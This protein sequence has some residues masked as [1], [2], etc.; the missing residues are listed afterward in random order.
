MCQWIIYGHRNCVPFTGSTKVSMRC[1]RDVREPIKVWEGGGGGGLILWTKFGCH[2]VPCNHHHHH[3]QAK[4]DM[5]QCSNWR[6][7]YWK[8]RII[9]SAS[10]AAVLSDGGL[11][12]L[13][14]MVVMVVMHWCLLLLPLLPSFGFGSV[15]LLA[16]YVP[17]CSVLFVSSNR[18]TFHLFIVSLIHE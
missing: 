9:L 7:M 17:S 16:W 2:G 15:R 8:S 10:C 18:V 13:L 1:H 3:H 11:F 5:I 14:P 6:A 4:Y 12:L